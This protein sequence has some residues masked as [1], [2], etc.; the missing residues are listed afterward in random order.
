MRISFISGSIALVVIPALV[1]LLVVSFGPDFIRRLQQA[2]R[3]D[4]NDPFPV[5]SS[6]MDKDAP[7]SFD[8]LSNDVLLEICSHVRDIRANVF[9]NKGADLLSALGLKKTVQLSALRSFSMVNQRLRSLN[10]PELFRRI[11]INGDWSEASR[12]LKV[13]ENCPALLAN[14]RRFELAVY[15]GDVGPKPPIGLEQR[16]SAVLPKM[17]RMETLVLSLPEFHV[18]SFAESFSVN[19]VALPTVTTVIV[20]PFNE[21]VVDHC[22]NVEAV[23]SDGSHF[24]HSRRSKQ[25]VETDPSFDFDFTEEDDDKDHVSLADIVGAIRH[26][27]LGQ[28][29]KKAIKATKKPTSQRNPK[30]ET[31]HALR[32]IQAA[33][34]A[35]H[36][37]YFEM[38]QWWEARQ[39]R[40]VYEHLPALRSL[41]MPGGRYRDTPDAYLPTIARFEALEELVLADASSLNV[42]FHP[43]GCGNVYMGPGGAEYRQQVIAEGRRAADAVARQAFKTCNGLKRVWIGSHQRAQAERDQLGAF[44][45]LK[46]TDEA[47]DPPNGWAW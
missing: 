30:P 11:K 34:R 29:S 18:D 22:S 16:L 27:V 40:Q 10:A 28:K 12:A 1:C 26:R 15:V 7:I 24:L 31:D 6:V 43:P 38:N 39:V 32:L 19:K 46:W 13:V 36:V 21:F 20:G 3:L 2:F 35:P 44:V 9:D 8:S 41:A 14:V 42:G 17:Q 37:T 47:R 4:Y 25:T 5:L 45:D 33:A 23:S